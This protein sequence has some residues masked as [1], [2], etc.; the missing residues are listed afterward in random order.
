MRCRI[1]F[2]LSFRLGNNCRRLLVQG[3]NRRLA[4][5]K[6]RCRKRP[7]DVLFGIDFKNRNALTGHTV[8]EP[9]DDQKVSVVQQLHARQ[10]GRADGGKILCVSVP[11]YVAVA[12]NTEDFFL[13]RVPNVKAA[14][15]SPGV[16]I[17]QRILPSPSY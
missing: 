15:V 6:F 11:E 12:G 2:I 13:R 8:A 9:V 10:P 17:S 14:K 1:V 4:I 3:L 7:A 5:R 16:E